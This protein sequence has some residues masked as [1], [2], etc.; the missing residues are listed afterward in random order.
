MADQDIPVYPGTIRY[1]LQVK[2]CGV[3]IGSISMPDFP[4]LPD[5][6]ST[7]R[8]RCHK[9]VHYGDYTLPDRFCKVL[10]DFWVGLSSTTRH[11]EVRWC[12]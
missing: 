11:E 6:T 9:V 7:I 2:N 8:V 4:R 5:V 3:V 1:N 12:A 10:L